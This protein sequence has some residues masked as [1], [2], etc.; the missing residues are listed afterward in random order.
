[1]KLMTNKRFFVMT[2][3]GLSVA[4]TKYYTQGGVNTFTPGMSDRVVLITGGSSGIGKETMKEIA[5]LRAK[6]IITGRDSQKA[7]AIIKEFNQER[8]TMKR[9]ASPITFMKVDFSDLNDV[10]R[11]AEIFKKENTQLD[12][13]VNNAGQM[14]NT[15]RVSKQGVEMTT[16]VNHLSP[17]YLTHLLMPLL[18]KTEESRVINVASMAHKGF[19]PFKPLKFDVSD[20]FL[21]KMNSENYDGGVAYCTS[22]LENILFTQGLENHFKKNKIN[23]KTASLHPGVIH[24]E[25][26]RDISPFLQNLIKLA[27]PLIWLFSKSEA[28]GAQTTLSTSLMPFSELQSGSYYKDCKVAP[29]SDDAA[30]PENIERTWN[31]TI[32]K[33]KE[34]TGEKEIFGQ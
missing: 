19:G 23:M 1:M 18:E 3:I 26:Q 27:F 34:L 22:K 2:G 21:S 9:L 29:V 24:S 11:F 33:L 14:N 32:L 15:F 13:L 4:A 25:L 12:V 30:N 5:R 28:Q 8:A 6:V 20:I 17:V 10:K 7:N 31:D 16:A